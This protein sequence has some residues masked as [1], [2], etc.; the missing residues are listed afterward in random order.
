MTNPNATPISDS[1]G[2]G[3]NQPAGSP[4]PEDVEHIN[5][6]RRD[7]HDDDHKVAKNEPED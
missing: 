5:D 3:E 4:R 1:E 6:D 7:G 2:Q